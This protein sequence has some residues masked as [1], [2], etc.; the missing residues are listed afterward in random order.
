MSFDKLAEAV[1][2]GDYSTVQ[3]ITQE[4]LDSRVVPMDIVSKGLLAGMDI[5]GEK[6]KSGDMFF[7]EVL[8]SAKALSGGM[9]LVK[10][11]LVSE[12][13]ANLPAFVIG[14]VKGDIHDIG[15]NLVVML[16]ESG[17]FKVVDLG[18]DVAPQSFVE[19]IE[20]YNPVAIGMSA[21][22]TTTMMAMKDTIDAIKET[23]L[24]NKVKILVGGAPIYP[25]FAE[26][27]GADGYCVDAIACKE[28]VS[29]MVANR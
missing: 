3:S 13:M 21:L 24:R 20:K 14:S 6:F 12:D 22:L 4:M 25:D 26:Q 27:I 2:R 10:P 18:V 7:P 16:M 29:K 11:L 1:Y 17:G 19:A 23:G 9:Q 28:M 8:M 5:V 15:K